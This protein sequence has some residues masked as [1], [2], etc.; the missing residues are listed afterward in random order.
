M[1]KDQKDMKGSLE[2]QLQWTKEQMR[3]LDKMD[4]KLHEMKKIAEYALAHS[5]S[6]NEVELLNNE[7]NAL[8][9]ELNS[10]E[11]HL[12]PIFH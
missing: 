3:I 5:L 7:L 2:Q 12:A 1:E 6:V 11:K 4:V 8:K 9:G 10:L